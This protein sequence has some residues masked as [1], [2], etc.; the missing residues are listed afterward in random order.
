M[1]ENGKGKT[2][3][4]PTNGKKAPVKGLLIQMNFNMQT[5]LWLAVVV[6]MIFSLTQLW[7]SGNK[8]VKKMQFSQK[9]VK[10]GFNL[11]M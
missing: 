1:T 6:A 11:F 2:P 8:V 9:Y 4:R 3:P 10:R 5:L 7:Q